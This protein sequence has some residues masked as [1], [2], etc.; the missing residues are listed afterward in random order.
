MRS[1]R[2]QEGLSA[3]VEL[4]VNWGTGGRTGQGLTSRQWDRECDLTLRELEHR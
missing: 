2:F 3:C 4:G 1:L